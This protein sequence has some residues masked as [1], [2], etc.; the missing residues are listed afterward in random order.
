MER[1]DTERMNEALEERLARLQP[2]PVPPELMARLCAVRTRAVDARRRTRTLWIVRAAAAAAV[3]AL[4]LFINGGRSRMDAARTAD[5]TDLGRSGNVTADLR[6][7][8][9]LGAREAGRWT[10]P[11]GRVYKVIHCLSV[12]QATW[13]DFGRDMTVELFKPKQRVLLLAMSDQ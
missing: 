12:D 7:E 1:F 9:F 6:Q 8:R 10:A 13:Q 2:A 5:R 11:D 4:A 3:V